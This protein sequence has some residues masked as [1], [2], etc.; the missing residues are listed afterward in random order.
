MAARLSTPNLAKI[1]RLS[2]RTQ[3]QSLLMRLGWEGD[4]RINHNVIHLRLQ[5]GKIWVEEDW[6]EQGAARL[7]R[8]RSRCW[9]TLHPIYRRVNPNAQTTRSPAPTRTSA[10]SPACKFQ[11]Q[12]RSLAEDT[13]ATEAIPIAPCHRSFANRPW[14]FS[15]TIDQ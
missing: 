13:A 2:D 15:A 6:I 1:R 14:C 10:D 7:D 12:P 8:F 3:D 5:E 9:V 4:R 11:F